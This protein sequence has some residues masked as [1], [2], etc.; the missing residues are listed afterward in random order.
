MVSVLENL[1]AIHSIILAERR[2]SARNIV[3]TA[4]M[5]WECVGFIIHY[6][7]NLKKLPE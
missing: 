4:E 6:V 3:E 7:L 1:D 2:I 5:S